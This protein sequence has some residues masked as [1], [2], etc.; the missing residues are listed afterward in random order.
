[1]R[2]HGIGTEI[3]YPVA[4]HQQKCFAYLRHRQGDFPTAEQAAEQSLALPI[5]PE[6]TD[7]EV[8][9]VAKTI[10]SFFQG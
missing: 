8:D 10:I 1:M 7:D 2:E 4:L 3:Y 5:F 9:L 6:L